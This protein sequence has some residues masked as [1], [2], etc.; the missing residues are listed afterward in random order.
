MEFVITFTYVVEI[1]ADSKDEAVSKAWSEF[2]QDSH[3][4]NCVVEE[5]NIGTPEQAIRDMNK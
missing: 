1:Q 2:V 4:S 5:V 3:L